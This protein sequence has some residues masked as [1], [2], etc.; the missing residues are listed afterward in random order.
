M[1]I[2]FQPHTENFYAVFNRMVE[3]EAM[4]YLEEIKI[5]GRDANPFF[6][7]LEVEIV[8]YGDGTAVLSMEVRPGLLNG[9]GWLQG[10][11]YTAL[12][13][14]AMALALYTTLRPDEGIATI[15]EGTSFLRGVQE[16]IIVAEGRVVK[17]GRRVA[18]TDA[19]VW[20]KTPEGALLAISQASFAVIRA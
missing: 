19:R 20:E 7:T 13:D 4:G 9:D 3:G 16:G 11:I 15:S 5:H 10:G 17:K 8:S 1:N 18:F 6:S 2:T 12:A 14:E